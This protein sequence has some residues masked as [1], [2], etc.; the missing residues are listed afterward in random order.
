MVN[1]KFSVMEKLI[2]LVLTGAVLIF[3]CCVYRIT[4]EN[5]KH[6]F[7]LYGF[8][9]FSTYATVL[10]AYF[11]LSYA[12]ITLKENGRIANETSKE[13]SRVSRMQATI[14]IVNSFNDD[15]R[16]Q[17]KKNHIFKVKNEITKEFLSLTNSEEDENKKDE[18]YYVLNRYEFIALGIR[19]GA[20]DEEMYKNLQCSN[21]L[22]LWGHVKPLIELIRQ[23][24]FIDGKP[25]ATF[26]QEFENLA[27]KWEKNPIK[28]IDSNN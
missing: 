25:R 20:F 1:P 13:T 22:K 7:Y 4:P 8:A 3:L 15:T 16:L 5:E 9:G 12:S 11:G 14:A 17:K 19:T 21:I 2:A 28:K 6:L 24:T 10:T 27:V 18:I 26:Y 23:E